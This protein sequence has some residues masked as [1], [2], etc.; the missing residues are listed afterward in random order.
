MAGLFAFAA[1]L[2]TLFGALK[3]PKGGS[4]TSVRLASLAPLLLLLGALLSASGEV[5]YH[6]SLRGLRFDL[7]GGARELARLGGAPEPYG[8]DGGE[9]KRGDSPY[10][11]F[12][13][14]VASGAAGAKLTYDP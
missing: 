14:L 11:A 2:I 13:E 12:G 1:G 3:A 7:A 6:F 8:P 5:I 9:E 10:L 4:E